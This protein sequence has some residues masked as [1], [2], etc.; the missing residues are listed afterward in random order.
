[1]KSRSFTRR[2]FVVGATAAS[3]S[4]QPWFGA[5]ALATQTDSSK[6]G[7]FHQ[8]DGGFLQLGM[9]RV[10]RPDAHLEVETSPDLR[11]WT[12]LGVN[13]FSTPETL[14]GGIPM[15]GGPPRGFLR[16]KA[17]PTPAP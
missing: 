2:Q 5:M 17:L 12:T 7:V 4:V 10:S 1:M 8:I 6:P 15:S 16:I 13:D 9:P 3:I 14:L 11:T